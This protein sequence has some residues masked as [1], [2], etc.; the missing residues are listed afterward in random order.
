MDLRIFFMAGSLFA[1]AVDGDGKSTEMA[2][3]WAMVKKDIKIPQAQLIFFLFFLVLRL[4]FFGVART[5]ISFPF[6]FFG[7][8]FIL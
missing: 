2:T 5:I 4:F 3:S 6:F 7:I 8:G 1:Y